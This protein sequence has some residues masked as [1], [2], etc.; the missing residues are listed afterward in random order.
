ML[1]SLFL[2]LEELYPEMVEIRRELHSEPE[3]SFQEVKT[4]K[5][6]GDYLERLGIEVKRNVGGRGVIGVIKGAKPGKTV[7][8]RADFDALPIEEETGLPFASKHKGI[9]HACGHDGH[10]AILLVL[11]KALAEHR[12]QLRG[13]IVLIHQF[14]EELAPGGAIEMI[15][16][17]CL[18]EVDV[19]F[20]THLWSTMPLGKI[21]YRNGPIMANADRFDLVIHGRGGHGASPH[22]TVD[23]IAVAS[24]VVA[25][26]Q[27]IV[28]RNVNPL[29]AAVVTVGSFHSGSAFNVIADQAELTGTVR[30][31]DSEVQELI[32]ERIEQVTKGICDSMGATYT[33]DYKKGYPAVINDEEI[34]N[35]FVKSV[36]SVDD[37]SL[38]EMEPV[39]GG[40]DFA[41]YLQKVPGTFFF[42][43]AGNKEKQI[44]YPHHHPKFDFDEKAM[45]YAAKCLAKA[46]IAY[47]ERMEVNGNREVQS[48]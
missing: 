16:D 26:L 19:V 24:S 15:K 14:A 35:H 25:Q 30:T 9:M 22:E 38:F 7:A 32:I 6:I 29:K 45:L 48:I 20:G 23:S 34:T 1:D 18:D 4:P 44:V 33:L 28:S 27:Q 42:T 13:T 11:A 31:F 46:A 2:R 8:L 5:F 40:E 41:Y 12:D 47:G 37:V 10:T 17:G 21:G 39:M 43:G 3:L 36:E